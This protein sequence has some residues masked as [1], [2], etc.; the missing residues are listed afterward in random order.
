MILWMVVPYVDHVYLVN[1]AGWL[2]LWLVWAGGPGVH[3]AEAALVGWLEVKWVWARA[4]LRL[5]AQRVFW[6]DR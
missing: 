2:G 6:Q 1:L 4:V 5:F 3:C